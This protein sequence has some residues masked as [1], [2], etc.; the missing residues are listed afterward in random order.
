MYDKQRCNDIDLDCLSIQYL[1]FPALLNSDLANSNQLTICVSMHANT[2][3]A[4]YAPSASECI[5]LSCACTTRN[6]TSRRPEDLSGKCTAKIYERQWVQVCCAPPS[7]PVA[8]TY[9]GHI[10]KPLGLSSIFARLANALYLNR[11]DN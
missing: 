2:Y 9:V 8:H 11:R 7:P 4:I 10:T 1:A 5:A 6:I 3:T